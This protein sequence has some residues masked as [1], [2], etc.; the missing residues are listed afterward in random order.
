MVIYVWQRVSWRSWWMLTVTALIIRVPCQSMTAH[1]NVS[2]I[3]LHA[4]PSTIIEMTSSVTGIM[5]PTGRNGTTAATDTWSSV[6]VR[7]SNNNR[8]VAAT[9]QFFRRQGIFLWHLKNK[10][11]GAAVLRYFSQTSSWLHAWII[12]CV[13]LYFCHSQIKVTQ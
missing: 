4:W 13:T 10:F 11:G 3:T 2:T 7:N 5:F 8:H 6:C 9:P 12:R 1:S